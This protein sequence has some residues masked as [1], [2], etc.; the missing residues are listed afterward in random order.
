MDELG[1]WG[2]RRGTL[3][4]MAQRAEW[5]WGDPSWDITMRTHMRRVGSLGV[6]LLLLFMITYWSGINPVGETHEDIV[7]KKLDRIEHSLDRLGE[8]ISLSIHSLNSTPGLYL[9]WSFFF[10]FMIQF[11]AFHQHCFR[12]NLTHKWTSFQTI[13]LKLKYQQYHIRNLYGNFKS[14]INNCCAVYSRNTINY[15]PIQT[16]LN[17]FKRHKCEETV[18]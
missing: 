18:I 6:G 15:F 3:T 9:L 7:W 11:Y 2:L 14:C 4:D 1:L 12:L 16:L 10:S 13:L 17:L 5:H 8:S